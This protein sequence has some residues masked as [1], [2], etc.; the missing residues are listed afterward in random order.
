[1]NGKIYSTKTPQW[2]PKQKLKI[3]EF[4]YILAPK[5]TYQ[6]YQR[7]SNS[8]CLLLHFCCCRVLTLTKP[9]QEYYTSTTRTEYLPGKNCAGGLFLQLFQTSF[10]CQN[11]KFHSTN[12][13]ANVSS[14]YQVHF[15]MYKVY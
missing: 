10:M 13:L 4:G 8:G 1:M 14:L 6:P 5:P 2:N 3:P 12:Q 9:L 7:Y 15:Y 11:P